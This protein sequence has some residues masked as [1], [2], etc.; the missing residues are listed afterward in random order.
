MSRFYQLATVSVLSN[1]MIPDTFWLLPLLSFTAIAFML[2]AYFIGL[3]QGFVLRNASLIAFCLFFKL[4]CY[5]NI[6]QY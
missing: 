1:M 6:S 2:E 5:G 4:L 3:K